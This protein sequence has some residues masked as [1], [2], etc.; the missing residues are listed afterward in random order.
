MSE[1]IKN[2]NVEVSEDELETV[3]GGLA[4]ES[5]ILDARF[6]REGS[7]SQLMEKS[8]IAFSSLV[9]KDW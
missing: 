8:N 9:R 4:T 3:A 7:Q 5:R 2:A 6:I 1:E